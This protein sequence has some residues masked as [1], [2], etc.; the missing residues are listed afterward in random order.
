M[1]TASRYPK[2]LAWKNP[3]I[4]EKCVTVFYLDASSRPKKELLSI[5]HD[6]KMKV[7]ESD[8]GFATPIHPTSLEKEYFIENEMETIVYSKKDTAENINRTLSWMK[9]QPDY[10]ADIKVF[11]NTYF[12]YSTK[13][14]KWQTLTNDCL[15]R[16]YSTENGSW[17]D[18][19]YFAYCVHHLQLDPLKLPGKLSNMGPTG[20]NRHRYVK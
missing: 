18:Q 1:I 5:L 8:I 6:W 12:M 17:R 16:Y 4:R 19:P 2:F 15:W 7:L 13:S 10:K 9:T 11:E 14:V 20:H 3:I